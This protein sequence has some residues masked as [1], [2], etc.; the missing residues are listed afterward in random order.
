MLYLF[1]VNVCIHIYYK[2]WVNVYLIN[3]LQIQNHKWRAL[4]K[5]ML[6]YLILIL[7]SYSRRDLHGWCP[8]CACSRVTSRYNF[9]KVKK[10]EGGRKWKSDELGYFDASNISLHTSLRL[11]LP[12]LLCEILCS[13]ISPSTHSITI[14]APTSTFKSKQTNKQ[15]LMSTIIS[16]SHLSSSH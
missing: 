9:H 10:R 7:S 13:S 16:S 5:L 2:N 12:K 11:F 15:W 4:A 1:R 3:N 8:S 14:K 6:K